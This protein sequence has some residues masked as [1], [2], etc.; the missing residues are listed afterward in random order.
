MRKQERNVLVEV[1]EQVDAEGVLLVQLVAVGVLHRLVGVARDRVLQENV[2]ENDQIKCFKNTC[3]ANGS[4]VEQ[5]QSVRPILLGDC[6]LNPGDV[7]GAQENK[8]CVCALSK[9]AWLILSLS[10]SLS[11][12]L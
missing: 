5:R 1:G 2:P 11:T 6:E 4:R 12:V 3:T 10:R 7:T 9:G 8:M